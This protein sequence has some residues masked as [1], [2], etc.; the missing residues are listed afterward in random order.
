MRFIDTSTYRPAEE[1]LTRARALQ[2]EIREI[3]NRLRNSVPQGKDAIRKELHDKISGAQA[4]WSELKTALGQLSFN[5]CWYCEAR[6]TRS[7]MVIDHFRPKNKVKERE[8]HPGYWWLALAHANFRYCCTLC[9]SLKKNKETGDTHGKSD[10][11]PLFDE[12]TRAFD[13]ANNLALEDP[14]LLDPTVAADVILLW[15][16][17]DGRA[18]P[19]Y[20]KLKRA[21]LWLRAASAVDV[22]N[23]ND[24][25]IREARLAVFRD[26]RDFV[27]EGTKHFDAWAAAGN[28][29]SRDTFEL[30]TQKLG[31]MISPSA[32]FS[33][34]ARA[35]LAGYRGTERE[36][37]DDL[38]QRV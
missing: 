5:K 16:D 24:P 8:E 4:L 28:A 7:H 22:Y 21:R 13:V 2:D 20:E 29:A 10:Y 37:V 15:F 11:F 35:I 17:E 18:V 32:E 14:C 33:A 27:E 30:M 23:L 3:A 31:E 19:K 36:W 26:V 12:A 6:E 34:A 38:L 25:N 9:N 1:W